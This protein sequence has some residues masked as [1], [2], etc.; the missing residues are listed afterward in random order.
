MGNKKEK[1]GTGLFGFLLGNLVFALDGSEYG[2]KGEMK[3][4][5]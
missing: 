5:C 3:H 4:G 2:N 1:R